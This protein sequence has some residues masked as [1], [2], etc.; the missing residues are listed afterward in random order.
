V[1]ILLAGLVM[2]SA[3][4]VYTGARDKIDEKRTI[5]EFAFEELWMKHPSV[6]E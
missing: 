6:I 2:T 1:G 3:K 4:L 5:K